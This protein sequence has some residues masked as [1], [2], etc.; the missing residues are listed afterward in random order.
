MQTGDTNYIYR[1]DLHKA[2]FQHD[3]AYGKCKDLERRTQLDKV[4]KEKALE[5]ANK[6]KY[7]G[8][9]GRLASMVH[10][11]FDKNSKDSGIKS[12]TNQ[13]LANELHRPIIRMKSVSFF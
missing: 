4:L 2:C 7:D 8:Y 5:I 12:M 13:Q 6:P 10:T 11:F 9:Q 3:M 1:N